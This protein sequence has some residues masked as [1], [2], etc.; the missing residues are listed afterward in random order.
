MLIIIKCIKISNRSKKIVLLNKF[1]SQNKIICKF[2]KISIFMTQIFNKDTNLLFL[3]LR[4]PFLK[5]R[6]HQICKTVSK[7]ISSKIKSRIIQF[8][9]LNKIII[10]NNKH[11]KVILYRIFNKMI[12]CKNLNKIILLNN[13]LTVHYNKRRALNNKFLIEL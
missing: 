12:F 5:L 11:L 2:N 4:N 3:C 10:F 8:N 7:I 6:K 13:L 1:S 9:Y